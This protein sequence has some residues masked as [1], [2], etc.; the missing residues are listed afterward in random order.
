MKKSKYYV[1]D[2]NKSMSVLEYGYSKDS[3]EVTI[4]RVYTAKHALS[5]EHSRD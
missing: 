2:F 5:A 4:G 3:K 1:Y